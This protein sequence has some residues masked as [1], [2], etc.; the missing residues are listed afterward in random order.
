MKENNKTIP[1]YK[2]IGGWQR[3]LILYINPIHYF[4][5][6]L[7][8]ITCYYAL[9]SIVLETVAL[10]LLN[11]LYCTVLYCIVLNCVAL[12][13]FVCSVSLYDKF[14]VRLLYDRIT[15]LRNDICMYVCIYV[16]I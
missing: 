15:D 16:C 8:C 6:N 7:Y 3:Q 10:I 2:I 14:H 11:V 1:I 13:L 5:Y 12:F 4:C 9:H